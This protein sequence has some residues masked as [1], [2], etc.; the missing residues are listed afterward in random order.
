LWGGQ[1]TSLLAADG[2]TGIKKL[3]R[4]ESGG[5]GGYEMGF[6]QL[7]K[8]WITPPLTSPGQG[9]GRGF[10]IEWGEVGAPPATTHRV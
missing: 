1:I 4:L 7:V 10:G 6:L 8:L 3:R 5:S 2:R 9:F